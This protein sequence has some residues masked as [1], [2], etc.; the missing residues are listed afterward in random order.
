MITFKSD[1][2]IAKMRRAGQI[3]ADILKLMREMVK[4]GIDTLTL[5]EAAE[6]LVERAATALDVGL[7]FVA[8][9]V[10]APVVEELFFRGFA[11]PSLMKRFGPWSAIVFSSVWFAASHFQL[12]QFPGLLAVGLV[13]A[14]ARVRTGRLLPCI[15]LH[16]AFN[17][18]TFGILVNEMTLA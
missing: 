7:L 12:I 11:L 3:V 5:D 18:V 6:D 15:A 1:R 16:M 8:I 10:V 17:A 4:P 14:Y 2:D 9:V 13:L